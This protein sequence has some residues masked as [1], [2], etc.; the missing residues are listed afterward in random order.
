MPQLDEFSF[1]S[2]AFW[3]V[4]FLVLGTVLVFVSVVPRLYGVMRFRQLYIDSRSHLPLQLRERVE[5][6]AVFPFSDLAKVCSSGSSNSP[7]FF[8]QSAIR[9]GFGPAVPMPIQFFRCGFVRLWASRL[10]LVGGVSE[11]FDYFVTGYGCYPIAPLCSESYE[12]FPT[13]FFY[14]L[15]FRR[16]WAI[17]PRYRSCHLLMERSLSIPTSCF[18][19]ISKFPE[20]EISAIKAD[21]AWERRSRWF[22]VRRK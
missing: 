2:N 12:R 9:P 7:D 14:L 11:F 16:F 21:F 20:A 13:N 22:R 6:P 10:I 19:N 17:L 5:L 1:F 4:F 15:Q 18:S 8:W 3:T